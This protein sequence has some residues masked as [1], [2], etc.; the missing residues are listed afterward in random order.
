MPSDITSK[1]RTTAMDQRIMLGHVCKD[2]DGVPKLSYTHKV[3]G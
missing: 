1:D 2:S 3:A